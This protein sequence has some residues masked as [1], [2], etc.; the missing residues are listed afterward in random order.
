MKRRRPLAAAV[1]LALIAAACS[2]KSAGH[3]GRPRRRPSRAAAP[4]RRRPRPRRR[5]TCGDPTASLRPD[6]ADAGAG[7]TMPANS[8]MQPDPRRG[9]SWSS[10]WTRT[11]CCSGRS[12]PSTARSRASTSTC[13]TRW[14]PPSSATPTTIQFKAITSAQRIPF[15]QNGTVDIVAETMTINCAR[16]QAGGLLDGVLPRPVRRCWCRSDSTG[17]GH[18]RPRRQ[19]GVR[20]RRVDLA[21][22]TSAPRRPTRCRSRSTTGPTAWSPCSATRSTPSRPT[23]PSWPAWPPRTRTPRSSG[24]RFTDEP[25]G[26]A[27]NQN[28]PGVRAVRQRRPRPDAGRRHLDRDLQQVAGGPP[29]TGTAAPASHVLELT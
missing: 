13:C 1:T 19:E 2:A 3:R 5:P 10:A 21:S 18:R 27:I 15:V 16:D 14:R 26:M 11:P 28:H 12:T 20:R 9:A 29:G 24:P 22:T 7:R 25:Y 6:G 17:E 23:T 8:F 4:G